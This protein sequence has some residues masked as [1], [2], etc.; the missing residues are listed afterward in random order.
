MIGIRNII[1]LQVITVEILQANNEIKY[2][3]QTELEMKESK[4]YGHKNVA[5]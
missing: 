4:H 2:E 1:K 3:L 5:T